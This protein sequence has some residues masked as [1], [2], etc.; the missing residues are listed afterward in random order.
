MYI[1]R[2]MN[3]TTSNPVIKP[4]AEIAETDI[5]FD[6]PQCAKSLAIDGRG[7]GLMITC[8]DCGTRIQVP[9]PDPA[10]DKVGMDA[11]AAVRYSVGH[12]KQATGHHALHHRLSAEIAVIQSAIDRMVDIL[13]EDTIAG[14]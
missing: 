9:Y 7:A 6:C 11:A 5:I 10:S 2:T 8:P 12:L 14:D 4:T 13:Q 1:D 3:S